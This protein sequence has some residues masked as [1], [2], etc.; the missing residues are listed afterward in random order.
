MTHRMHGPARPNI[1][2]VG[3]VKLKYYAR[4]DWSIELITE[5]AI[6]L[7]LRINAY[8]FFLRLSK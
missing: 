6:T 4:P 5:P 1:T 7:S 2:Y 8:I 3:H